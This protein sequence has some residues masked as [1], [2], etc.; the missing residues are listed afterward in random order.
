MLQTK[1]KNQPTQFKD[2]NNNNN[3]YYNNN[4]NNNNNLRD[5]SGSS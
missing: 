3:N 2:N 5:R 4:N 1:P